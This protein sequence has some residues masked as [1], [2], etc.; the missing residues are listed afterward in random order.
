MEQYD[1]IAI[2]SGMAGYSGAIRAAQMGARVALVEH[3]ELGGTCLNRGCIP[4]K[5]L[6]A[7]V[8][9]MEKASKGAEFGFHAGDVRPDFAVM[10]E[11]KRRVAARLVQGVEQLIRG[12]R[13]VLIRGKGELLSADTVRAAA[14]DGDEK[15]L[16]APKILLA[17]G[18]EPA[19][20]PAFGIDGKTVLTSD[21]ALELESPPRSLLIVGAGAI[22]SEYARF[23][24]ACGTEVIMVEMENQVLPGLDLRLAQALSARM[25][26]NG[27]DVRVGSAIQ[28]IRVRPDGAESALANGTTIRTEKVLVSTGRTPNSAGMGLESA[29]VQVENGFVRTDS[30]MGTSVPGLFAAGDLAG[31]RLL[32][33]TAAKEGVTAAEN[34]LGRESSMDY[35]V[36]P[37]TVFSDPEIACVGLT[38]KE[39]LSQGRE[40]ASGLFPFAANGKALAMDETDGFVCIVSDRQNGELLGGQIAGPHASDLIHEIA[41]GVGMRIRVKEMA[42]ILHSHPTFSEALMEAALDVSGEAIHRI[43]RTGSRG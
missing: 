9:A 41:L 30:R 17:M 42:S 16:K 21:E 19:R 7:S 2:G 10:M 24:H 39:A 40:I 15:I 11:R 8:E 38:E 43:R 18:S 20:R 13:I 1:F 6:I 22:G 29:G 33:Y 3:R 31:K 37:V 4:T 28:E 5:A 35:R 36:V 34:A 26:K 14:Q 23:F 27:I 12:H 32:A 25:R